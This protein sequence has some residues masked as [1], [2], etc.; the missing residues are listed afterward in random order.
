MIH[1]AGYSGGVYAQ[2]NVPNDLKGIFAVIAVSLTQGYNVITCKIDPIPS[3]GTN[4]RYI[5]R[6]KSGDFMYFRS[7]D[8]KIP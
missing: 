1:L 6:M 8:F 4:L 7:V 5:F 3:S 2:A